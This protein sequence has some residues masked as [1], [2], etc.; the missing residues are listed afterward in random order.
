MSTESVGEGSGGDEAPA[1]EAARSADVEPAE[2]VMDKDDRAGAASVCGSPEESID[3]VMAQGVGEGEIPGGG[4]EESPGVDDG[5][6]SGS[7]QPQDPA[8]AEVEP[9]ELTIDEGML[10]HIQMVTS[11]IEDREVSR[12]EI[13]EMLERKARQ[14]SIGQEKRKDYVLRR[15]AEEE[16]P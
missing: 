1:S 10:E 7:P 14:H 3:G 11:L 13:L 6:C 8:D 4:V 16:P 5:D 12:E 2:G 9:G 15:L